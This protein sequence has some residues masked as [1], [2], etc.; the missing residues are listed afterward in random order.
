[1]L[2]A[3]KLRHPCSGIVVEIRFQVMK[4]AD[5]PSAKRKKRKGVTS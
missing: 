4:W 5:A 2:C 1:M 3:S